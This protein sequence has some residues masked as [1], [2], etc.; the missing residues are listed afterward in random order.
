MKESQPELKI[1]KSLLKISRRMSVG[2]DS[3]IDLQVN[4]IFLWLDVNMFF[5]INSSYKTHSELCKG[6]VAILRACLSAA[7]GGHL[8]CLLNLAL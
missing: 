5:I 2:N 4:K 1:C 6:K 3:N 8:D 7:L